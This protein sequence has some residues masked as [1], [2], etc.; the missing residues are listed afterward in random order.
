[1]NIFIAAFK[2]ILYQPLFNALV[3]LYQYFPGHDFGVAVIILTVLIRVIFYPFG[4]KAIQSQKA[5]QDLQPKLKEIQNKYKDD[6]E[7]Q[8]RATME[9]YQKEK[10][11]P[12]SGC[13]PLLVQFPI[14]LALYRVF[15]KG[16]SPDYMV[17]LYSFVPNP[18]AINPGFL[19]M[20]NLAQPNIIL[21]FLAGIAQFFQSKMLSP[22]G[23]SATQKGFQLADVMQKQM[24]YF[25][26]IFTVIILWRLPS[27]IGLYWLV[28]TIF[29]IIQ[30]YLVFKPRV[31][32][33]S[34][35][36]PSGAKAGRD[37]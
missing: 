13:L 17:Y 25:F 2:L 26:P 7:R 35:K 8:T 14:L 1:M 19:G 29:S 22:K 30:Q 5:L 20:I 6:K 9:L 23:Q 4:V 27:A 33:T 10:I 21:A 18:G 12:F 34:P 16:L 28:A 24:I 15:W 36:G 37:F 3:V 32:I 31:E 11:N